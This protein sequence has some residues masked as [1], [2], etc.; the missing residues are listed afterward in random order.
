M[1]PDSSHQIIVSVDAVETRVGAVL[2][3]RLS[4]NQKLYSFAIYPL[5]SVIVTSENRANGGETG[6][7]EMAEGPFC[8]MEKDVVLPTSILQTPAPQTPFSRHTVWLVPSLGGWGQHYRG[9]KDNQTLAEANLTQL[10]SSQLVFPA[11]G[12]PPVSL[13][14][15]I[16]NNNT[17]HQQNNCLV[18]P[19]DVSLLTR[20]C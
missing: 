7:R 17:A 4:A 9:F 11:P 15:I 14:I 18:Q 1:Q 19:E 3:Q 16:L 8:G 10:S 5:W 20:K 13:I 12:N 2:S 6:P